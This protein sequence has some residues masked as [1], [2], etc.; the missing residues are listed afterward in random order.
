MLRT[1]VAPFDFHRGRPAHVAPEAR[2]AAGRV[3]ALAGAARPIRNGLLGAL[4]AEDLER[5]RP[6]LEQVELEQRELL[7][8]SETPIRHVY[9]PETA[10]VSLVSTLAVGGTVEIGTAGREGMAGLSVFLSG[11]GSS[12]QA[13][14]QISGEAMRIEA[15]VFSRLASVPGPFHD[16][17]L[18][19][20]EAFLTQVAQTAACNGAHF[21]EERCARWLLVTHDRVDGGEIPLTHEFLAFMLG[22]RRPGV[23]L[24]MRALQ[25]KGFI[26]YNRGRIVV[27]DRT[28]LEGAACECYRAVRGHFERLLPRAA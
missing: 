6:H 22:V 15:T 3:S 17:L 12:V 26:R 28:A 20:S 24:V 13:F 25:D 23:T 1:F 19:Y 8:D 11:G 27:V 9:F 21:V 16:L 5:I 14:T 4:P 18:R 10:V 2:E 7:F